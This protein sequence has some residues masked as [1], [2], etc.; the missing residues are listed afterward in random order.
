MADAALVILATA[1]GVAADLG[2]VN[3]LARL[4]PLRQKDRIRNAARL[5]LVLGAIAA[6]LAAV[7]VAA[8][9]ACALLAGPDDGYAAGWLLILAGLGLLVFIVSAN[10]D[11]YHQ[12]LE[13]R[14]TENHHRRKPIRRRD[15]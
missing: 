12:D 15:R 14:E 5:G 4:R 7:P 10:Q 1:V 9:Y 6:L 11:G 8:Y 3:L 13:R 2:I